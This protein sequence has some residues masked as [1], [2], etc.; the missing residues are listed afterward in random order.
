MIVIAKLSND[1]SNGAVELR[2]TKPTDV[3][4]D[5]P[6]KRF[7]NAACNT[8]LCIGITDRHNTH[9]RPIGVT[10]TIRGVCSGCIM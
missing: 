4:G 1:L 2:I 7:G 5:F 9:R 8:A 3:I 6:V 10:A